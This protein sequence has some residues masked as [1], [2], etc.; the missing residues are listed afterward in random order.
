MGFRTGTFQFMVF[1][2][3]VINKKIPTRMGRL[4]VVLARV[5]SCTALAFFPKD[6]GGLGAVAD[7]QFSVDILEVILDSIQ[8]HGQVLGDML[9]RVTGLKHAQ[10]AQFLFGQCF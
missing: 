6:P 1:I 10:D 2:L 7:P 3:I 8:T 5:G 9:I 4:W